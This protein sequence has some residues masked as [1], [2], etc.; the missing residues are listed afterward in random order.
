[1]T[2]NTD[3]LSSSKSFYVSLGR[4]SI[5]A[6]NKPAR[7]SSIHKSNVRNDDYK[8]ISVKEIRLREYSYRFKKQINLIIKR[9]DNY[10]S[11]D[12]EKYD[13]HCIAQSIDEVL[14]EFLENI[15]VAWK[16]YV[17]CDELELTDDAK[18]LR[19]ILIRDMEKVNDRD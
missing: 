3:F 12:V 14:Q 11:L 1:M 9:V 5:S 17:E 18:H 8:L 10:W 4:N 6:V 2:K 13:I 7:F 15:D 16:M 19:N